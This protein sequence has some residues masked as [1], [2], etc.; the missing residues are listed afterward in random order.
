MNLKGILSSLMLLVLLASCASTPEGGG[1]DYEEEVAS[2]E[3]EDTEDPEAS[4]PKLEDPEKIA[5]ENGPVEEVTAGKPEVLP[6]AR[7]A[8]GTKHEVLSRSFDRAN[9]LAEMGDFDLLD[10]PQPLHRCL[11]S[12]PA[13]PD[14]LMEMVIRQMSVS[15]PGTPSFGPLFPG[16]PPRV[17]TALVIGKNNGWVT[18]SHLTEE[19]RRV[20]ELHQLGNTLIIKIL[21][22]PFGIY[23][24]FGNPAEVWIRK[25]RDGNLF[26]KVFKMDAEQNRA[27]AFVGYCFKRG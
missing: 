24:D 9:L 4:E 13:D 6:Q 10:D 22:N 15:Y 7:P 14:Q 12:R 27:E 17:E 2:S 23:Q 25:A 19:K 16:T 1:E 18:A 20:F 21:P 11:A 26:F 5:S 3:T 8:S